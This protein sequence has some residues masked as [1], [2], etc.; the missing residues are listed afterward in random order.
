MTSLR[1]E[2]FSWRIAS[3]DVPSDDLQQYIKP[4]TA[5]WD[6]HPNMP[7]VEVR[8]VLPELSTLDWPGREILDA[9]QMLWL[10]RA[11][12]QRDME[13]RDVVGCGHARLFALAKSEM[14]EEVCKQISLGGYWAIAITEPSGGSDPLSM[15][16]MVRV[17][18][19]KYCLDGEKVFV[20]RVKESDGILVFSRN[21]CSTG[22]SIFALP[23]DAFGISIK[24]L[25]GRGLSATSWSKITF[26]SVAL[27]SEWRVGLEGQ[28]MS[29][30]HRHFAY[31]RSMMSA[32]VIGAAESLLVEVAQFARQRQIASG[33]LSQATHFQISFAQAVARL[34]GAWALVQQAAFA[35]C[36]NEAEAEAAC[37]AKADAVA[38]ALDAVE[39]WQRFMGARSFC[40]NSHGTRQSSAIEA[41]RNADGATDALYVAVA[42]RFLEVG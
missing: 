26:Q 28:G 4:V 34:R 23:T 10:Y 30:L 7:P 1:Q 20:G 25:S 11:L 24:P 37:L 35:V 29:L 36:K 14:Q 18:D 22:I 39:V 13:W 8:R 2:C 31:W 12:G 40:A 32:C 3:L 41:F 6:Q 42:K 5:L 17:V 38:A 21:Q 19:G 27:K 16:T 9:G 15:H 33:L